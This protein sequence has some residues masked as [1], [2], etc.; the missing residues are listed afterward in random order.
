MDRG[1]AP[2]IAVGQTILGSSRIGYLSDS[3]LE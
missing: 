1:A 3:R 2:G